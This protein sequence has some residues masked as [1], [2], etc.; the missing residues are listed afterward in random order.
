MGRVA[1]T[2]WERS[3]LRALVDSGAYA[4]EL[5]EA[6][7][8]RTPHSIAGEIVRLGWR[9]DLVAARD[10]RAAAQGRPTVIAQPRTEEVLARA[11]QQHAVPDLG[12]VGGKA[13]SML[14]WIDLADERTRDHK[15]DDSRDHKVVSIPADR[16]IGLMLSGDAH[17]GGLGVDYAAMREHTRFLYKAPNMYLATCGDDID[18]MVTHPVAAARFGCVTSEEQIAFR[19]RSIEEQV[20]LGKLIAVAGGN[21]DDEFLERRAGFS[22]TKLLADGLV[23]YFRGVGKLDIRL[24]DQLYRV[25]LVHRTRFHS[26]MNPL[27]GNKR[28]Q[29]MH[30]EFFGYEWGPPDALVTAHTH[31]PAISVEGALPSER[32]WY[33]KTGTYKTDDLYSQRLFGPGRIGVPTL[34]MH[35]ERHEAVGFPTPFEAYRYMNGRDWECEA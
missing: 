13:R 4:A 32:T 5:A 11:E 15:A 8:S 34:V 12:V 18:M 2:E 3:R 26:F 22:L 28:L 20:R 14:E 1:W 31:G 29:Q 25:G 6:F 35:P 21:H 17:F 10:A 9:A 24:G 19:R 33:I 7:P 27:H 16:P 23:P 30:I